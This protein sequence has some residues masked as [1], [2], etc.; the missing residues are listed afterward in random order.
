[1]IRGLC[2]LAALL[3]LGGVVNGAAAPEVPGRPHHSLK[4]VLQPDTGRL[5]V[6]DV[7]TAPPTEAAEVEFLLNRALTL[8]RS[9]PEATEIPLGDAAS[10]FGINA[11]TLDLAEGQVK[12]YRLAA[13]PPGGPIRLEYDGPFDFGLSDQKE[14][15]ARGFR[16]TLGIVSPEGVYLAGSGFWYPHLGQGLLDFDV[17]VT[18][19][20]GWHVVS[21]GSGTS[22]DDE[23]TAR[24]DSHGP[25]DEIYLVGGPLEIYR[26]AAGAVEALVYLRKADDALAAK[27]L[28]ATAQ[29][30]EMYRELI[31]PYPY[32]KFALVENFWETGYG[33]PSFTL[34]G[35]R[36]I[37]FPFILASSYPHEILHNWWGNSVFV[38]YESG[39]W[40]EGLTAYMA[41]H[42]IKEQRGQGEEYR[43]DTLQRYRSYVREGRDF[44]LTE[45]RSRHSAATEAVGY[46]KT[47]MG[48]HMLRR[49][50]GD[51]VFRR[52]AARFYRDERGRRASF[53]DVRDSLEAVSGEDL[54]RFF[55]DWVE[56]AG[57]AT[58]EASVGAVRESP[59]GGWQVEGTLRQTQAEA[60]YVLDVP[61]VVQTR[62]APATATVRMEGPEAAFVIGAEARPLGLHVDPSFDVFRKLDP[63]EIPASIGQIFGEPDVLAVLPAHAS[64]A[65]GDGFRTLVEGWRSESH[66]P[67]LVTDAELGELP[68]DRAV[69]VLGRGNALAERLFASGPDFTLDASAL[70]VGGE[71]LPLADHTLVIV[72]RHPRNLEKAIGW[73]FTDDPAALPGLGRKLPHYGKYSYLGFEGDEPTND[74]KGQWSPTDSPLRVDLRPEAEHGK[75][76]AAL[77][78][79]PRESLAELPPVFS[80][81]ALMKHVAWLA[82]PE[83]EGRGIGTEGLAAAAEYIAKQFETIGLEPG[84]DDGT[85]FQSFTTTHTP[86]GEPARL[87]NVVGVLPGTNPGWKDQSALLTAHYDHLGRGWP[88]VHSGDEGR[89]HPGAD[90]NASGVAV[91]LE[92]A[93]TLAAAGHPRRTILFLAFTGEEAGRLGSRHYVLDP[94]RPLDQVMGVINLDTVGRLGNKKVSVLATGTASEWPHIFRGASYVTGVESRMIP[95]ALESSDQKSFIDRGVPAV[96][97]FTDA[98]ADYHRPGDTVDAVDGAGLVKVAT[99]VKEGIGYLAEREEPLTTTIGPGEGD[100][101]PSPPAPSRPGGS[102]RRVSFGTMP[103]FAFSGPGVKVAGVVPGS[104][105][106]AA[107]V[108]EDDVLRQFAGQIVESLRGYAEIL[109]GLEPGQTVTVVLDRGGEEHTL[110]A[111]LAQR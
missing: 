100:A 111:T 22:R 36:V 75:P 97:V 31:G 52:W 26:E 6:S 92:L 53:S 45:F 7:V 96:Q 71:T 65:E 35:P 69:W 50:L 25:V 104:P 9:E 98:H 73:I 70:A 3:S 41:D 38:D 102:G 48:F 1:M 94:V 76:L 51:D 5:Q 89:V 82:D 24:W 42:L 18:L 86:D 88:D 99:F 40:C 12:R 27:Y 101:P 33:M 13:P 66:Q 16:E 4:V 55:A 67:E 19:P 56:R 20:D 29:Y 64:Q 21:Q 49:R 37:R 10:F 46:G 30:L 2:S 84:G 79:P 91:L 109:E 107:G 57:A 47:L 58:L 106:E 61:V 15:Y 54:S 11:S 72:R 34:L 78:L 80:R 39:N 68:G 44:P 90:D 63:R 59:D 8:T 85:Y 14:E 23:G 43:R 62:G 83:R 103:D 110:E 60:P 32:G 105:A 77:A 95:E 17:E 93:R 87:R 28:Q 108:K 81:G 74:L